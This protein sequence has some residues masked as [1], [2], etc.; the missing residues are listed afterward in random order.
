MMTDIKQELRSAQ[1]ELKKSKRI[2]YYKVL[3]VPKV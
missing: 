2:D 3:D 1:V